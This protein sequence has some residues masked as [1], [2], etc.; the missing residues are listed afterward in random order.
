M[1]LL[2]DFSFFKFNFWCWLL[3]LLIESPNALARTGQQIYACSNKVNPLVKREALLILPGFGDKKKRR[4]K[5]K[6]YF[7]Q[8]DYDVF[9]ADYKCR[10]SFDLTV[11][12]FAAYYE[13]NGLNRYEK[14]HVFS[15]VLGSWVI[16]EY[17]QKNGRQNI[18]TIIYDRSP[19][20]ERAPKIVMEKIPLLGKI[21]V[22]KVLAD[23]SNKPYPT[24]L[25]DSIKIG[26]IV[27]TK[28]TSLV[29]FFK[30]TALSYGPLSWQPSD[31]Q[32]PYDDLFY[33][34]LNHDQMYT[35]FDVIGTEII[36]FLE[37][38]RFTKTARRVMFDWNVFEKWKPTVNDY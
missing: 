30:K 21:K 29:R 20:Q 6:A 37:K 27:E 33:T 14:V 19:L 13:T 22:G 34:P 9:I 7:E 23:F 38:N 1:N 26:I 12:K 4:K 5:Q 35:R 25:M 24:L 28:A 32:Q 16:N 11:D 18:C 17:I 8:F 2:F 36:H 31:L 3:L 15:Y 10:K